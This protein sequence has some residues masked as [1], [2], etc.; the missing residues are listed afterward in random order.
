[1]LSRSKRFIRN[2]IAFISGLIQGIRNVPFALK[3]FQ[4][5]TAQQKEQLKGWRSELDALRNSAT[6]NDRRILYLSV[7]LA[8]TAWA[9]M[10]DHLVGVAALLLRTPIEKAGTVMY[11]IINFNAWLGLISDL[12]EQDEQLKPLKGEWNKISKRIR[13]IKDKRDQI[14]HHPVVEVDSLLVPSAAIRRSKFD[15]RLK[16]QRL[17]PLDIDEINHLAETVA[18][19]SPDLHELLM[20]MFQTLGA[21]PKNS[22]A[23][24]S[25]EEDFR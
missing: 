18:A 24:A 20:E 23:P 11:S 10:E 15:M 2:A 5:W 22:P 4:G 12:F 14:A 17:R 6:D 16:S 13:A 7:G 1:M 3:D 19:I 8:I 25:P 21:L 9:K